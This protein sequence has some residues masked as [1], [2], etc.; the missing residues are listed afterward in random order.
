M[1]WIKIP[2]LHPSQNAGDM[3]AIYYGIEDMR[4]WTDILGAAITTKDRG[5]HVLCEGSSKRE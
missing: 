1:L 3:L 5:L 2:Y 4:L